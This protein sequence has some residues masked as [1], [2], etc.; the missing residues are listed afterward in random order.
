MVDI[1]AAVELRE[2]HLADH[3]RARGAIER[4]ERIGGFVLV[5]AL[6]VR[7]ELRAHGKGRDVDN[8]E[9]DVD[10]LPGMEVEIDRRARSHKAVGIDI[11]VHPAVV[12]HHR[13]VARHTDIVEGTHIEKHLLV[14][15]IAVFEIDRPHAA[16]L[17]NQVERIAH[18]LPLGLAGLIEELAIVDLRR[19]DIALKAGDARLVVRQHAD[20][21]LV[22]VA[23]HLLLDGID[24]ALQLLLVTGQAHHVLVARKDFALLFVLDVGESIVDALVLLVEIGLLAQQ[25]RHQVL[26]V[27]LARCVDKAAIAVALAVA[28]EKARAG[29]ALNDEC[30]Q[31]GTSVVTAFD[32]KS[33]V[34]EMARHRQAQ[35][36]G[37]GHTLGKYVLEFHSL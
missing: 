8:A 32:S 3:L 34:F 37:N 26:A 14:G 23:A 35:T 9:F 4:A 20:Q 28:D 7:V 31:A 6:L 1:K 12:A 22:G 13:R 5:L 17:H 2:I 11:V 24:D 21:R 27:A 18:L 30:P 19:I 33:G 10:I 29:S 36:F 15:R 25:Q 16:R